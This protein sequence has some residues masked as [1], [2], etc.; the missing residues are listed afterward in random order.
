VD[1]IATRRPNRIVLVGMMGSGK[2]TVGRELAGRTGWP[3][4]DNDAKLLGTGAAT[5]RDLLAAG[6]E[7]ALRAAEIAALDAMLAMPPPCIVAAAAGTI[8]DPGARARMAAAGFVVWLRIDTATILARGAGGGR[9]WRPGDRAAWVATAVRER[10]PLYE[11]VADLVLDADRQPVE[12]LVDS[13][14]ERVA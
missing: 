3:Y 1:E 6:D 12:R 11:E 8:V 9:P 10:G 2:T 5:A 14:L 7:A 4:H 13:I